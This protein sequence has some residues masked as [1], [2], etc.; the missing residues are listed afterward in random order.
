M[1]SGAGRGNVPCG[2]GGRIV[3]P[4]AYAFVD[5]SPTSPTTHSR[6]TAS[7]P[8]EQRTCRISVTCVVA[9]ELAVSLAATDYL[10]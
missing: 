1:L 9:S 6:E 7:F 5:S 2:K 3:D 4:L 8:A 10:V